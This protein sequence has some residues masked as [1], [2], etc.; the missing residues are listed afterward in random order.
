M[1]QQLKTIVKKENFSFF[2]GLQAWVILAV[3]ILLSMF[4]TF[5]IGGFFSINNSGLFS[6]FYFQPYIMAFLIPALTMKL[7]AEERKNGTLEFLFTQPVPVLTIV[8][9]KFLSAWFVC[10]CML[11]LSFPLWIYLNVYFE[12][13][14]L[15]IIS[16]YL[17]CIIMSGSFCALGCLI[18]SFC[19]SPAISY[20]WSLVILLLFTMNNFSFIIKFI[21]LPS[22]VENKL[23]N[24][25]SS[26]SQYYDLINGQIGLDNVLF[27]ILLM[28]I[29]L[30][31][32]VIS[33]EYKK[34]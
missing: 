14:N 28:L 16:G 15:N 23:S 9:G 12:A 19:S 33:I 22:N 32:N 10:L 13:D 34:N 11:A 26:G 18:S 29:S 1:F 27:F 7:W 17:A 20:L 2:E 6:F 21:H 4:I 3:Y 30:W 8:L 25:L 31:L 24:M 5:F